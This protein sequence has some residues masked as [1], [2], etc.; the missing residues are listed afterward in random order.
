MTLLL[1][2]E[3]CY[4]GIWAFPFVLDTFLAP[5]RLK[6]PLSPVAIAIVTVL[7]PLL[8]MSFP[9]MG[10]AP[11]PG[12]RSLSIG[13]FLPLPFMVVGAW[14]VVHL[15][16]S[17][18]LS[19]MLMVSRRFFNLPDCHCH[20]VDRAALGCDVIPVNHLVDKVVRE[21]IDEPFPK[22]EFIRS[23]GESVGLLLEF[24]DV[25]VNSL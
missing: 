24:T 2:Q 1:A 6:P 9:V 23:R 7:V 5:R 21:S 20:L 14:G 4:I 17:P 3:A 10:L 8:L 15:V 12:M 16:R 18:S 13:C 25:S 19:D 11:F 22:C